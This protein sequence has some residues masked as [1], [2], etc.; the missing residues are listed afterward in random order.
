[1]T[2]PTST[3]TPE[4]LIVVSLNHN[5]ISLKEL[6]RFSFTQD[7]L[8][9]AMTQLAAHP[10]IDEVI[11][12]CTCNRTEFFAAVRSVKDAAHAIVHAI[13]EHTGASLESLR[14]CIDVIV[15]ASAVEHLLR[16]VSGLE[17]IAV[18]DAQILGQVK[19]AY[20]H[21]VAL[22]TAPKL[23][24]VLFQKA[25][26]VAKR[27]RSE[28]GLG[29]GRISISALA[30]DCAREFFGSLASR[31]ATV[32]GA[33][34]MGNLTAKYLKEYGVKEL[35]IVNRSTDK[36][37]ELAQEV[38]GKVYAL[39]ELDRVLADSDLVITGTASPE[40]LI[41]E[42]AMRRAA[43]SHPRRRLVI[44]I[45]VPPDVEPAVGEVDGVTLLDLEELRKQAE[46]NSESRKAELERAQEIIEEELELF[47]PWPLPQQI[48]SLANQLGEYAERIYQEEI[49]NL[50]AELPAL[51][52][53]Q[54][55][56]IDARM[57]R[58]AERMVLAPRR[59]L[60]KHGSVRTCPDAFRCIGELF[61]QE[62][63]ARSLPGLETEREKH[64]A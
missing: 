43:L 48:N 31:T 34:K 59:N 27:V 6:H 61:N 17:S 46:I 37:I 29:K 50:S 21:A 28:T 44:D 41:T 24:H 12:L 35:R 45:A 3:L 64:H 49:A 33:G 23:F 19:A 57:K 58:L 20:H 9:V 42:S 16:L 51:T 4:Q 40:P 15:D 11:G 56:L 14:G 62:C 25:F 5:S 55:E 54:L 39:D 26:S 30:V 1:M 22:G 7:E 18:G 38:E 60:R 53:E 32:V 10:M 52:S 63:G 47:G 13:A 2:T 36:S 8:D